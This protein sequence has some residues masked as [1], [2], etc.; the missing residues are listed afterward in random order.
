MTTFA[1][2]PQ[3]RAATR[4]RVL[5]GLVLALTLLG[6]LIG[7]ASAQALVTKVGSTPVGLQPR[8]NVPYLEALFPA[9]YS[10]P[11]GNPVLH[12]EGTYAIYWDPTDHYHGDWQNVIDT[13]LQRAGSASG[14]LASVFSVD[15]QY[16]DKSNKPAYYAQT[17]KGAYTDTTPYPGSE[18]TDPSPMAV[19]DRIGPGKTSVCLTTAQVAA[20][21]EAFVSQHSLQK[22]LGNVFYL[23]TPPG[24]TVCLDSGGPS[25]HCSDYAATSESYDNS[26]CSYH[27]AINPGELASGGAST[28]VYGV[29]PW[30]AGGLGDPHL[31]A[32]D[33]KPAWQCQ[34]GGLD[35]SSNPTE[36]PEKAKEH[37]KKEEEELAEK[38]PEEKAK[39]EEERALEGPHQQEPNQQPCP[40]SDGGCDT[41]LADLIINQLSVEQQNIVTDPL[42]NGWKDSAGN[43]NTDECR[44]IFAPTLGGGVGANTATAAGTLYN[45]AFAGG[46]YYLNDAFNLAAERLPY[47]GVGCLTGTALDPKFTAPN[48]VNSGEVVGFDGMESDIALDAGIDFTSAGAPQSNYATYTWSFGDGSGPVSGYAP[49]APACETPWLSPCAASVFH[50]YAYGGIY[51]VTLTVKDVGGNTASVSHDVTVVGPAPPAPAAPG[52]SSASSSSSTGAPGSTATPSAVP[53]P[54]AAAAVVSRSLHKVL[55]SG[56]AVRYSVNEQVTGHFEVM[57]SRA[58]ATRLKIGGPAAVG[59]PAG[60]APQVVIGKAI[61]VTTRAGRSTISIRLSRGASKRLAHAHGV[62]M[63]LRLF[64][65]NAKSAGSATVVS[66]ARLSG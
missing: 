32:V 2:S 10:N 46:V 45:Q 27:A 62:S 37:T 58:L 36:Q 20:Q 44:F 31:E 26:F 15:T 1:R 34:D 59:L 39:V 21:V 11:E 57:I 52:S 24:V 61:L 19:N 8:T 22:G 28:I 17:F 54:V 51:T 18:C 6:A 13:Y 66:A 30:S 47:P 42:L 63:L 33:R 4:S 16:T 9:E 53:S 65:R 64:V 41:G 23:L 56:L 5:G 50:S 29:I 40:T 35:P 3:L 14:S 25:G 48:P 60:T 49:G 7:A 38:T 12:G 43:E 55:R